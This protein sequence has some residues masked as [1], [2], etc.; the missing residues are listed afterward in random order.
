MNHNRTFSQEISDMLKFFPINTRYNY[1]IVATCNY[2]VPEVVGIFCFEA[3]AVG[4]EKL[5]G[6]AHL[7]LGC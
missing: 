1:C 2:F 3:Y 4:R 5:S 6:L 7:F